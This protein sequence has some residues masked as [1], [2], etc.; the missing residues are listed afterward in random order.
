[1]TQTLLQAR[2]EVRVRL[3]EPQGTAR[4]WQDTEINTWLNEGCRDL[5]RTTE[6]LL[7]STTV[8]VTAATQTYTGPTDIIRLHR[9]QWEPTGQSNKYPLEAREFNT[10]DSIWWT[11]Q[12]IT[13]GHPYYY[14]TW[15][16]PPA[17]SIILYP[18]PNVNGNLR[19]Y[20]ARQPALV[21]VDG[22]QLD[23]P[24]GW[25][26]LV[27]DYA[28]YRA[29]RAARDPR[30]QESYGKYQEARDSL[31]AT[32]AGSGPTWTDAPGRIVPQIPV[33]I[34]TWLYSQEGW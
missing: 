4:Q 10:M 15:G 9:V 11:S 31:L 27:C 33:G 6:C 29:Q 1:M 2:T 23:I 16:Y 17:V 32:V 25:H 3:R 28:E 18:T 30:W 20:Y 8:A 14:T 5:A 26:D 21:S 34:P 12:S 24:E 19:V 13:P 22:T 7:A